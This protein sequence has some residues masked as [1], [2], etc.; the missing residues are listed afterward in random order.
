M[1]HHMGVPLPRN[2]PHMQPQQQPPNGGRQ[3]PHP[4]GN[5]PLPPQQPPPNGRQP[6]RPHVE[7]IQAN[8]LLRQPQQPPQPQQ[9]PRREEPQLQ[10]AAEAMDVDLFADPFVFDLDF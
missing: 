10:M 8:Q 4:P 9:R 6:Q 1:H 3:A 2:G 5:G 7:I